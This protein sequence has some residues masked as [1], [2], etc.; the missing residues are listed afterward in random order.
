MAAADPP[1]ER[2]S[3]EFRLLG[4]LAVKVD[5]AG[6]RLATPR[7]TLQVLAYLLLHRTA[8]VSRDHLAFLVWPDEEETVARARLRSTINELLHVLPQPA[9]DFLTIDTETLSWNGSIDLWLDVDAFLDASKDGSRLDEAVEYYRGDLL[10]QLYDEWIYGIRERLRNIYV[11][12]LTRLVAETRK[13]GDLVRS[14]EIARRIL[15]MDPWREDIVRRIIGLRYE[16]GDAAG[17]LSEYRRFAAR[18]RDEMGVDP[19]PETAA[20]AERAV[21]GAEQEYDEDAPGASVRTAPERDLPLPFAG[22]H[23]EMER[24]AEAWNRAKQRRG[25]VV[26]IGGE[27]G[28]GKSRLV[29]E[30][31]QVVEEGGGRAL[32]GATGAPE[33]FPYQSLVEALRAQL[34]LVTALEIGPTWLAALAAL[35]PEL[36]QRIGSLPELPTLRADEQRM[37]LFEALTRAIVELARPRPLLVVLE[38]LHWASQATFDALTFLARRAA[39]ARV[40]FLVTFRD[41]E[42]VARHPLRRMQRETES[43]GGASSLSVLRLE[44]GVVARIIEDAGT[45]IPGSLA[46]FA[47]AIHERSGG[48]PLFLTQLLAAPQSG[49]DVP[50]TIASLVQARFAGLAEATQTVAEIAALAGQRFSAEVVRDVAGYS[51]AQV[52]IALDELLDK[53]VVQETTGR[54][55][56]PYAFGHHLVQQAIAQLAEPGRLRERSRRMARALQEIYPERAREFAWQIARHLETAERREEASAQYAVAAQYALNV[57]ALDDARRHVDRAL[58]LAGD[59][60]ATASLLQL[61]RRINERSANAAAE[62][63]DLAALWAIAGELDDEDLRCTVLMRRA[64]LAFE[65]FEGSDEAP[66]ADRGAARARSP[67]GQP[68]VAGS[69]G[70]DREHVLFARPQ[71]RARR[72]NGRTRA[73]VVPRDRRSRGRRESAR[74][75]G[76]D[77]VSGGRGRSLPARVGGSPSGRGGVRRL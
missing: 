66:G 7:K 71:R 60:A 67:L 33:S 11:G 21:A 32:Y 49:V 62:R 43:A 34:P 13:R 3:L 18:L 26:F 77:A 72:A 73:R 65:D 57:G 36:P 44:A 27:P 31:I 47:A 28:I 63:D 58:P 64:R 70:L 59:R 29:R 51:D 12:D 45:P 19:M 41:D 24:L 76:A 52:S 54:G 10:P 17:A 53:R 2:R 4:Q 68:G 74:I 35:L 8:P 75:V 46:G 9:H 37:R 61:R 38:D 14:I 55:V 20:A 42:V 6:F 25:S 1:T 22:R 56:L 15:E 40:L 23:R 48:N 39:G 5:G 16:S 50:P 69:C 30:F